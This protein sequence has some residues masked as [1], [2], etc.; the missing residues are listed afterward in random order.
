MGSRVTDPNYYNNLRIDLSRVNYRTSIADLFAL[1]IDRLCKFA[2]DSFEHDLI[3]APEQRR[4]F[5]KRDTLVLRQCI[6][7]TMNSC[8][9]SQLH[10]RMY[11]KRARFQL[12]T[13]TMPPR[14]HTTLIIFQLLTL[15]KVHNLIAQ[16]ESVRNIEIAKDSKRIAWANKRDSSSMRSIVVLTMVF[17]PGTFMSVRSSVVIPLAKNF[18]C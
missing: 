11:V 14:W 1:D 6:V 12:S 15:F 13:V 7:C 17:L 10:I 16:E 3:A 9:Y 4:G 5:V 2:L 18:L 8:F